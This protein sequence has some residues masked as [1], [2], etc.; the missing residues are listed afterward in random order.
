MRTGDR[1]I[2]ASTLGTGLFA[3]TA[4][5]GVVGSEPVR[6]V[7]AV[8]AGILFIVGCIAFV[9]GFLA[10]V[11]RSRSEDIDMAGLFFLTGTAPPAVRRRLRGLVFVQMAIALITAGLRPFTESAFGVLAPMFG[12]GLM[13]LWGGRNGDF[14][15]PDPS[16]SPSD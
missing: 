14:T 6:L 15:R 9:A 1:V 8:V 3:V 10:G 13:A 7:S 11:G 2:D 5:L 16:P 12:L 4:V